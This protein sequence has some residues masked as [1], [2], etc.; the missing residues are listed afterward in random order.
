VEQVGDS[1]CTIWQLP[2]H[3]DTPTAENSMMR[4]LTVREFVREGAAAH[5]TPASV[6]YKG[7]LSLFRKHDEN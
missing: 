7:T 2:E 3:H 6:I 5:G 4:S 1:S